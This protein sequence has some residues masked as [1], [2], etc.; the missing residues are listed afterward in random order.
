MR[1]WFASLFLT[2]PFQRAAGCFRSTSQIS[3][4]GLASATTTREL[5]RVTSMPSTSTRKP[6]IASHSTGGPAGVNASAIG[7]RQM[8]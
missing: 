8:L 7:I 3:L 6:A 2:V 4:S 1:N 5:S